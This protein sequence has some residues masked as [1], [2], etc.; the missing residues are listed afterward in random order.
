VAGPGTGLQ[1]NINT[2]PMTPTDRAFSDRIRAQLLFSGNSAGAVSGAPNAPGG[3]ATSAAAGGALAPQALSNVQI[4]AN[5]GV[6]TLRGRVNTEA[7]RQLLES[8]IRQM[9]GVRTVINGVM[10]AGPNSTTGAT[11]VTTPGGLTVP[12]ATR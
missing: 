5:N 12:G 8:R 2:I 4:G 10:V 7:D 1:P 9:P 6:V 3:A 11:G